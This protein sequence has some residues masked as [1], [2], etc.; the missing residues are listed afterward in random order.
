[1]VGRSTAPKVVKPTSGTCVAYML[2]HIARKYMANKAAAAPLVSNLSRMHVQVTRFIAV[3][4][5]LVALREAL[6]MLLHM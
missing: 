2:K 1:M 3:P 6:S 5:M 4:V